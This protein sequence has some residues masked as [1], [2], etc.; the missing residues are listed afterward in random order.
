MSYNS[1]YTGKEVEDTIDKV[2]LLNISIADTDNEVEEPDT[3][4][5]GGGSSITEIKLNGES[6]GTSGVIEL[7]DIATYTYVA[8]AIEQAITTTLN[9]E[10]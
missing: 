6:L 10:V 2:A 4:S 8:N 9:A 5:P 7:N 3:P 1:K